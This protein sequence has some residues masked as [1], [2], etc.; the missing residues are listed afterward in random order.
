M[1]QQVYGFDIL[2]LNLVLSSKCQIH[3]LVGPWF[4]G[5]SADTTLGL[6]EIPLSVMSAAHVGV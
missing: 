5:S 4:L 3:I 2:N 1:D 6:M